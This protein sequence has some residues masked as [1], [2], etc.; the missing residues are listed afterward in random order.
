M[1]LHYFSDQKYGH[2]TNKQRNKRSYW[3]FFSTALKEGKGLYETVLYV[4]NCNEVKT[5]SGRGRL[6]IRF[7][8]QHHRLGDVIQFSFSLPKVV[9]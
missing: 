1:H 2:K 8:L 3:A 7:C 4:L 5:P 6:F 9:K